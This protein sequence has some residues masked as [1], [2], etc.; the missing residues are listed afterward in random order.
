LPKK[1]N[2]GSHSGIKKVLLRGCVSW[3]EE[4]VAGIVKGSSLC[5]IAE[6]LLLGQ[7]R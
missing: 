1:L 7:C 6:T 4:V 2:I 5:L 3:L